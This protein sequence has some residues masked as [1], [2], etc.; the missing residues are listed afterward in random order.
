MPPRNKI[1][2][3]DAEVRASIDSLLIERG[4]S[5]YEAL[6]QIVLDEH[7]LKIGKSTL[8]R[9]GQKLERRLSAIRASTE[10]A[11]A[12]AEASPDDSDLRSAAVISL[13]QSNLFD[14]MLDLEEASEESD[15]A[16]RVKLLANAGRA[17]AET[18]R[19]SQ[20]QKKFAQEVRARAEAAA[21]S[22]EAIARKGG[23]SA[24]M[25]NTI[26]REILGIAA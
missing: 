11:R 23:M 7:G 6:E 15:P 25:V 8:G 10:A 17:I 26:R 14:A 2:Q 18:S 3:L 9:Y 12:I 4:F 24:E 19:A 21:K 13:V 5:G 1:S 20:G 22:V 16:E